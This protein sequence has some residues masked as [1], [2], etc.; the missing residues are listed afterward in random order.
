MCLSQIVTKKGMYYFSC[1]ICTDT[2]RVYRT[3]HTLAI[4]RAIVCIHT[5]SQGNLSSHCTASQKKCPHVRQL[6]SQLVQQ[7]NTLQDITSHDRTK[8]LQNVCS[9]QSYSGILTYPYAHVKVKAKPMY[10]I[11]VC[12]FHSDA[13]PVYYIC[14]AHGH[15][16]LVLA[17]PPIL[18]VG[19]VGI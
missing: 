6:A 4:Y 9:L 10:I 13:Y 17:Y 3:S 5:D 19:L 8:S 7:T 11:A 15:S 18:W 14:M 12:H 1:A 2:Y 16:Q